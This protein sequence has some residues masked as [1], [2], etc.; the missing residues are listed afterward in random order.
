MMPEKKYQ[1][2]TL[3]HYLWVEKY[4]FPLDPLFR[5]HYGDRKSELRLHKDSFPKSE[6]NPNKK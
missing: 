3:G 2:E 4:K 1:K 5:K 6:R